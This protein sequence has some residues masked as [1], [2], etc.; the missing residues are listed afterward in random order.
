MWNCTIAG[1]VTATRTCSVF[2]E[3]RD[4]Q[5]GSWQKPR[6]V[7]AKIEINAKGSQRRYVVTNLTALPRVVYREGDTQRGAVRSSRLAR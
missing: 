1:T 7:V 2:E 3:I 5:A 4:Y 6:R